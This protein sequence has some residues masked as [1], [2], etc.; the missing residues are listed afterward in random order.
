MC[1]SDLVPAA[2]SRKS[3]PA[4]GG[5]GDPHAGREAQRYDNPIT[6]R[7]AILAHLVAAPGPLTAEELAKAFDLEADERFDALGK[8]LAAMV[9]DG[10]LLMNRRGGFAPAE[11][12]DLIAG[13]VIVNP[14]GFGFLKTENGS[15]DLF[16]PP[17]EMRKVMHVDRVLGCVTGVQP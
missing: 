4:T 3:A 17:A 5:A 1:S 12:L 7:E 14:D 10:Q 9:R 2:S 15:D 8:R 13:R 16:L 11:R 6:S